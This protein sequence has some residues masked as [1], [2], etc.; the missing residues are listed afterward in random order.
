MIDKDWLR[1]RSCTSKHR[2]N[3]KAE[4]DLAAHRTPK[5]NGRRAKAYRCEYCPGWHVGH[6]FS[7]REKR[8]RRLITKKRDLRGE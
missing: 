7:A 4:A 6:D 2:H 5:K 1:W 3:L 8:P